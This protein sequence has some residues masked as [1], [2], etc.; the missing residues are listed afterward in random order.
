MLERNLPIRWGAPLVHPGH[1]RNSVLERCVY[2]KKNGAFPAIYLEGMRI[3]QESFRQT[4]ENVTDLAYRA[5]HFCNRL[6]MIAREFD[7]GQQG[8]SL[9][10]SSA[11]RPDADGRGV[12]HL[13][14]AK[15]QNQLDEALQLLRQI[16]QRHDATPRRSL[17]RDSARVGWRDHRNLP[18]PLLGDPY[19]LTRLDKQAYRDE[20]GLPQQDSGVVAIPGNMGPARREDA[21]SYQILTAKQ[22]LARLIMEQEALTLLALAHSLFLHGRRLYGDRPSC[23]PMRLRPQRRLPMLAQ[24]RRPRPCLTSLK[25]H[26]RDILS[27]H[28]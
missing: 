2:A 28:S 22:T 3:F 16:L 17:P 8:W 27:S 11:P 14:H 18:Y 21:T 24:D 26:R 5:C 15:L 23:C 1:R 19:D 6:R 20:S 7:I 12:G 13:R 25:A 4:R 9:S 10:G